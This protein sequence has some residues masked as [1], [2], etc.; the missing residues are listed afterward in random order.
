MPEHFYYL[1]PANHLL[2]I[3]VYRT[4]RC[5][6]CLKILP[7]FTNNSPGTPKHQW[8]SNQSDQGQDRADDQH[9]T[10]NTHYGQSTRQHIRQAIRQSITNPVHI[11]GIA[12]HQI[13]MLVGIEIPHRQLFHLPKQIFAH[14]GHSPLPDLIQ[15]AVFHINSKHSGQIYPDKYPQHL[16]QPQEISGNNIA[17]DNRTEQIR[18]TQIRGNAQHDQNADDRQ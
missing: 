14:P 4:Q 11:V 3:S 2:D 12:T 6:L 18:T 13:T 9:Q 5:L 1:L 7:T 17:I 15:Q 16:T 8:D 10:K